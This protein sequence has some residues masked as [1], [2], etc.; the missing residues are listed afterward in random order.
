MPFS[1]FI[2]TSKSIRNAVPLVDM[3]RRLPSFETDIPVMNWSELTNQQ[4]FRFL[5]NKID[6]DFNIHFDS[7]Q[8]ATI[9]L[10]QVEESFKRK[11]A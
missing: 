11:D 2:E 4:I 9:K 3:F 6:V 8:M 7:S 5:G 1:L 10:I